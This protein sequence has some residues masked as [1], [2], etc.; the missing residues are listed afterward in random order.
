MRG[1]VDRPEPIE[2][3]SERELS[4]TADWSMVIKAGDASWNLVVVPAP[5]GL[6]SF[7]SGLAGAA[8]VFLVFGGNGFAV[9]DRVRVAEESTPCLWS[10][11]ELGLYKIRLTSSSPSRSSSA[12]RR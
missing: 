1:A 8:G 2:A 4:Q 6:A 9:G 10:E 11:G 3:K 7:L 12:L 5:L